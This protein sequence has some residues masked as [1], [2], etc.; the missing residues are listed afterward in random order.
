MKHILFLVVF[1]FA[2]SV[3]SADDIQKGDSCL[4]AY[5][6][7]EALGYYKDALKAKPTTAVRMKIAECL[8]RQRNYAR[9][10]S[11]LASTATDSLD[12]DS[13]RRLF[14]SHQKLQH[15]SKTFAFGK[16]IIRRWPMDGEIVADLA[17]EYL[18]TD[19]ADEAEKLCNSYWL[20]DETNHAVND[21]MADIYFVQRQ[22][23]IACNSYLLL[24]QE[25]DSTYKNLFNVGICYEQ[26]EKPEQAR[27]A[28]DKAI[29][30]SDSD[31]AAPLYH[32]GAVLNTLKEYPQAMACF[33]RA[34][35]VLYPSKAVLFACHRGLAEGYYAGKD[36]RRAV[37]LFLQAEHDDPTSITT[38]YYTGV[39]Y[40]MLDQPAKA[41]SAYQRFLKLAEA[42]EHPGKDLRDMMERARK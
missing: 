3:V 41:R 12:H 40:D 22:Y 30:L 35:S 21:I 33:R 27:K 10:I 42:F 36:Y 15:H 39:C 23:D 26:M 13:M 6:I 29:E 9:C 20:R 8:F 1:F 16:E 31:I 2:T 34:M 14:Y 19:H 17:R 32:Q 38:P 11:A 7:S 24:L 4:A 28:L 25:G 18:S 37:D 5:N